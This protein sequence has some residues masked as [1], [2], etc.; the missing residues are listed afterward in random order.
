MINKEIMGRTARA[1]GYAPTF[2]DRV[3][4][5]EYT[6]RMLSNVLYLREVLDSITV[7]EADI[8]RVYDQFRW[9]LHLRHILIA[10]RP[11]AERV[12]LDLLRGRTSWK[13]AVMAYS[14]AVKGGPEGD[15]GWVIRVG[16]TYPQ[17]EAV[18]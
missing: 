4:M 14:R 7:S 17:A 15:A 1:A 16:L 2:E 18:Y 6:E 12:R 10:D 11:T 13:N 3:V 8:Q 9:E 5:R